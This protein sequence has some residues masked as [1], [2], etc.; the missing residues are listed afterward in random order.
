MH[1]TLT[2][3]TDTGELAVKR[4]FTLTKKIE[5][6]LS[7]EKKLRTLKRYSLLAL[8]IVDKA[9]TITKSDLYSKMETFDLGP[10]G[11]RKVIQNI[12]G[13]G[14]V[15][16]RGNTYYTTLETQRSAYTEEQRTEY[17]QAIATLLNV[18]IALV[19][20]IER[21]GSTNTEKHVCNTCKHFGKN[22]CIRTQWEIFRDECDYCA[23]WE[24]IE[25]KKT[26]K[27]IKNERSCKTWVYFDEETCWCEAIEGTPESVCILWEARE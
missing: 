11:I 27:S 14:L 2:I 15:K 12:E 24:A 20:E 4:S 22:V 8:S 9:Q 13:S 3:E 26:I 5:C 19:E 10:G 25:R 18:S 1:V 16:R 7:R 6:E 21:K 17:I 23:H